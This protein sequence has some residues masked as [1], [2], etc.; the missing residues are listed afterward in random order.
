MEQDERQG[1]WTVLLHRSWQ[2]SLQHIQVGRGHIRAAL[3]LPLLFRAVPWWLGCLRSVFQPDASEDASDEEQPWKLRRHDSARPVLGVDVLVFLPRPPLPGLRAGEGP[4]LFQEP[5][6]VCHDQACGGAA[7]GRGWDAL[8]RQ[9][10]SHQRQAL[11]AGRPRCRGVLRPRRA[12]GGLRAVRAEARLLLR[13]PPPARR[14]APD[15][16]PLEPRAAEAGRQAGVSLGR[17][18]RSSP[19]PPSLS[20]SG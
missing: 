7:A 5:R 19:P 18:P 16:L 17:P 15:V 3:P 10:E 13:R 12:P 14:G 6:L 11:W 1:D 8:R 20:R 2:L 4:V 9:V